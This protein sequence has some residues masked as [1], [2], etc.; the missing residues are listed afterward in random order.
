MKKK[1]KSIESVL[2]NG[3]IDIDKLIALDDYDVYLEGIQYPATYFERL[4]K[5]IEQEDYKKLFEAAIEIGFHETKNALIKNNIKSLMTAL[6]R[7]YN[8]IKYQ[9][10]AK[11]LEPIGSIHPAIGKNGI[12]FNDIVNH[13]DLRFFK[14]ACKTDPNKKDWALENII[15]NRPNSFDIQKILLDEGAKI[16]E[17]WE[18]DDG[19][20]YRISRDKIDEVSTQLLKN[21]INY[22]IEKGK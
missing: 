16:H 7:D 9:L 21:Q 14:H 8:T 2:N 3:L 10:N 5:Y 6:D 22:L 12:F 4:Q 17:R 15:V 13:K 11:Y 20:G 18:E 1:V 19:W